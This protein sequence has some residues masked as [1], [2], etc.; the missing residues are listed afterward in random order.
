[1]LHVFVAHLFHSVESETLPKEKTI[2]KKEAVIVGVLQIGFYQ[3]WWQPANLNHYI[4]R[5]LKI[6]KKQL[7]VAYTI[8]RV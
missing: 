7:Y 3:P 8:V 6:S 1:M 4:T 2:P 5:K